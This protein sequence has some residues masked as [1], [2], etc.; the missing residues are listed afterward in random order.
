MLPLIID[1]DEVSFV[2]LLDDGFLV[3]DLS[4][5]KHCHNRMVSSAAALATVVPSGD[6]V[7]QSTLAV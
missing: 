5:L 6:K 3:V 1:R 7:R 2:T 4:D